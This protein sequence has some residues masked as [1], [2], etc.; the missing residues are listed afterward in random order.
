MKQTVMFDLDGT[1][2]PMD[3]TEFTEGYFALLSAYAGRYGYD[4]KILV[5]SL[6]KATLAMVKNDGTMTNEA[7]FWK[8][9]HELCGYGREEDQ[10]I[11]LR[12]YETDFE[13]AKAFCGKSE[14]AI[15]LV[16]ELYE[17]KIDLILATNPLFPCCATL[18]RIRW[19]GLDPEMFRLITTYEMMNTCKPNPAYFT[20]LL[21]KAHLQADQCVM[22]GNDAVEDIAAEQA[23]IKVFLIPD[24]LEHPEALRCD[25]KTGSFQ[26]AHEWILHN[27]D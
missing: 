7:R 22:I 12:F 8:V 24:C 16:R 17:E 5:P 3:Q 6:F 27:C 11:L 18:A 21:E 15:R 26:E 10:K 25:M 4:Q 1:L 20:E 13:E 19:A 2:L 9:F 23:G 14:E